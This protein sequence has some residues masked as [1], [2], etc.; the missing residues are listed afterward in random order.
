MTVIRKAIVE[1]ELRNKASGSVQASSV[2]R[3]TQEASKA[4]QEHTRVVEQSGF[5]M[6][7]SFRE[8]GEGAFRMARGLT[9]LAG[10]GSDDMRKL[11]Q[12]VA[13]AQGAFD[14]FAGGLKTFTNLA[15]ILGTVATGVIGVTGALVVGATAWLRYEDAAAR[16]ARALAANKKLQQEAIREGERAAG[17][18]DAAARQ[19]AALRG[20]ELAVAELG[21]AAGL[22]GAIGGLD[23]ESAAAR[24][25]E[26]V[27]R[28][29]LENQAPFATSPQR[30]FLL[31]AVGSAEQEQ[32]DLAEERVRI[33]EEIHR[34]AVEELD[35][36]E[37][38]LVQERI[39]D[40][41]GKGLGSDSVDAS[42]L[43]SQRDQLN[44]EFRDLMTGLLSVIKEQ[45]SQVHAIQNEQ[46]QVK[47]GA[48]TR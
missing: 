10:S 13:L 40:A 36:K 32:L 38:I 35:K 39:K 43:Q 5:K 21:G 34:L 46:S 33:E 6:A 3:A 48:E 15:A 1:V 29:A 14:V 28:Q 17:P 45:Q 20:T 23:R 44:K 30:G 16:T 18:L 41:Q 2:T 8:A 25:R 12:S 7:A 24:E 27:A 4:V 47:A 42:P 9:L 19:R 37:R 22:R 26:R 31:P 11:V